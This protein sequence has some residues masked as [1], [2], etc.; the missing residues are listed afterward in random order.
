MCLYLTK[1]GSTYYF[2][3]VIP[4]ELRPAFDG[5][6][7]FTFSLRT[8]EKVDAKRKR[9]LEAVRTDR[10]LEEAQARLGLLAAPMEAQRPPA[11]PISPAEIEQAEREGRE[12]SEKEHRREE[13][14]E[15]TDFLEQRLKGSTA[16]MPRHLRAFRYLIER[17]EFKTTLLQDQL[18]AARAEIAQLGQGH[19]PAPSQRPPSEP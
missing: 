3:R 6:A 13:L 4:A 18:T 19:S 16:Q 2:R 10:L 17:G 1:R 12:L 8:K 11:R 5:A 15:W 9:D 7:E 14:S